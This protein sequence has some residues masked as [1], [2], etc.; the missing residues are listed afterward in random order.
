[1]RSEKRL[2]VLD[3]GNS[4]LKA[5]WV[6]PGLD[7]GARS[8][9]C[10]E[11]LSLPLDRDLEEGLGSWLAEQP[12]LSAAALSSVGASPFE[13]RLASLVE[14]RV[15]GPWLAP[16]DCGLELCLRHPETVGSDRLFA[17]RGA[18]LHA[19]RAIVVDAGTALTVDATDAGSGSR[20]GAGKGPRFLGGAIAPGPRLLRSALV[21]GGARLPD[22]SI[23]PGV[24]ALGR[25][26]REALRAGVAVGFQ[27]SAGELVRRIAQELEWEQPL[28][29]YTGG[30][31]PYL[32]HLAAAEG[33]RHD[34]RL[35]E[36][37]IAA[38]AFEALA[39]EE[40]GGS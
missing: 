21:A 3:L 35:V 5:S 39:W 4:R 14:K 2:L 10:S 1:M 19:P 11:V 25:E 13:R 9:H 33:W 27:G 17:A 6:C 34:P 38:A 7:R 36:K 18:L 16:P 20:E 8:G 22:F 32:T 15:R 30:A 26:T 37:G 29:V 24:H 40:G 23:E 28:V 31:S 12:P